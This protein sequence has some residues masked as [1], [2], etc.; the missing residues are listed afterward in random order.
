[1][2]K[3]WTIAWFRFTFIIG[4]RG[5]FM[6]MFFMPLFFAFIFGLFNGSI[7]ADSKAQPQILLIDEDRTALSGEFVRLLDINSDPDWVLTDRDTA[8]DQIEAGDAEMALVLG[9]GFAERLQQNKPDETFTWLI[10]Q[11]TPEQQT[12][13]PVVEATYTQFANVYAGLTKFSKADA[14]ANL[15]K[16]VARLKE[17]PQAEITSQIAGTTDAI[18]EKKSVN[19]NTLGFSIMFLMFT[20]L[21]SAAVILD[22]REGGTWGRILVSP[23]G[24]LQLLLGYLLAFFMIG[25]FQFGVLMLASS[26]LFGVS[27]GN[28]LGVILFASLMI[29]AFIGLGLMIGGFVKTSKQQ[30]AIGSIMIVSTSMLGGVYWPLEIVGDLMQKIALI[31]PQY[32]A[33]SGFQELMAA[34]AGLSDIWLQ[35]LILGG[36]ALTFLSV[37]L[38]RIR[39]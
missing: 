5:T 29:I 36:F 2:R 25:W 11:E 16:T 20:L 1:M 17:A 32:W 33:I 35:L 18:E 13:A 24:R 8:R 23:T 12:L 6:L 3:I 4:K 34:G 7:G 26:L 37:G 28:I 31:V 21:S 27:W 38:T 19:R 14:D 15:Q 30:Q 22:E 10:K 9:K 39:Y